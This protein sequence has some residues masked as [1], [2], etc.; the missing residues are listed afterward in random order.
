MFSSV[1][2]DMH[3]LGTP[4]VP[5]VPIEVFADNIILV[6]SQFFLVM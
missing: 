3:F 2:V 1:P 5:S 6:I 4:L